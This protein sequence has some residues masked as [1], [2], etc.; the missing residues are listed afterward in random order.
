M[1]FAKKGHAEC[2][3]VAGTEVNQHSDNTLATH[4]AARI[5]SNPAA[6]YVH[7]PQI[8]INKI[9]MLRMIKSAKNLRKISA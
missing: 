1:T 7:T 8:L 5:K 3:K 2:Q 9:V 4:V 6:I